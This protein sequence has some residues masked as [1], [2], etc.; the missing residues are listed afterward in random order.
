MATKIQKQILEYLA[1]IESAT[2][3]DIYNHCDA[4]YEHNPAKH[5]GALLSRMALRG[6]IDRVKN[7]VWRLAKK[8]PQP[9]KLKQDE[10]LFQTGIELE[11]K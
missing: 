3:A 5:F 2:T 4:S 9:Q 8:I 7:G 10:S 1:T 6:Q 11:W